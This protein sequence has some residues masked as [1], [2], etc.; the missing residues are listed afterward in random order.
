[1]LCNSVCLNPREQTEILRVSL[2]FIPGGSTFS[3]RSKKGQAGMEKEV[4]EGKKTHLKK[5]G[6]NGKDYP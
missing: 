4:S 1:M 2:Y 3:C 5:K 6:G